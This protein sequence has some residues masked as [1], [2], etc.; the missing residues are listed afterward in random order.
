MEEAKV[1]VYHKPDWHPSLTSI[2]GEIEGQEGYVTEYGT[3][4]LIGLT[5]TNHNISKYKYESDINGPTLV[6]TAQSSLGLA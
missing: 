3:I 2:M 5:Q 1:Q 4:H 6:L